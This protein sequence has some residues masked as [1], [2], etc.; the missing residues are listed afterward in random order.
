MRR[1]R[2]SSEET[3]ALLR[4]LDG[5]IA[6][7]RYFLSARAEGYRAKTPARPGPRAFATAEGLRAAAGRRSQKTAPRVKSKPYPRN[8]VRER[9]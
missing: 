5:I 6:N 9:H 2:T 1:Y 7:D 4:E 3:P 8:D